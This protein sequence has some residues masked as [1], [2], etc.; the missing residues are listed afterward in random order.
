[1]PKT[2]TSNIGSEQKKRDSVH[3]KK[4]RSDDRLKKQDS[5]LKEK[6]DSYKQRKRK[7]KPQ[8]KQ[9]KKTV[10]ETISQAFKYVKNIYEKE[11]KK[12]FGTIA[13]PILIILLVF[14]FIIMIFTSVMSGGGFTLGTYAAQ[15]YDLSEAE[16]YYTELA[17]NFN[18]KILKV[19]D[20][21]DWKDGLVDFGAN[22]TRELAV[23]QGFVPVVPPER[24]RKNPWE[25]DK[26]LYKRRN[27]VERYFLRIKR[28]RR[29]FTRYDKL[30]VLYLGNLTL[31]MIF[32][33]I[34]M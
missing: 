34:L 5:R 21:D 27:E 25:Y 2:V 8:N 3:D 15:D 22:E 20:E 1:M 14:A 28:F 32:D 23:K 29:V 26:E 31:A 30:D 12:F 4:L 7:P 10:K 24:N 17:Y 18:Q 16:K 6:H 11:V 13:V 19:S 9:A 33:A